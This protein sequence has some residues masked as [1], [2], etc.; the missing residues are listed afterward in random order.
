MDLFESNPL[1]H[2]TFNEDDKTTKG[3]FMIDEV[4]IKD[5]ISVASDMHIWP[6]RRK[7]RCD[8]RLLTKNTVQRINRCIGLTTA[9]EE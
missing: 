9:T 5:P 4:T 6:C 1:Y 7:I 2:Q 3:R 8:H